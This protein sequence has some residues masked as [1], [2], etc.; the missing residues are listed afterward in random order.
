M[1]STCQQ[2]MRNRFVQRGMEHIFF[3]TNRAHVRVLTG[4]YHATWYNIGPP[5][6]HRGKSPD[7]WLAADKVRFFDRGFRL[8]DLTQ[9]LR[10]V[11]LDRKFRLCLNID[12]RTAERLLSLIEDA[13]NKIRDYLEE[14]NRLEAENLSKYGFTYPNWKKK[15][16]FD[17]NWAVKYLGKQ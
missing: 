4:Y 10:G 1:F 6:R 11:H 5:L 15:G 2:E 16:G 8:K 7:C 9:Y 13:P 17:W 14:T 12:E 3:C